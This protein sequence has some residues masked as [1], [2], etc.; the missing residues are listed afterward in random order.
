MARDFKYDYALEWVRGVISTTDIKELNQELTQIKYMGK[1][2]LI[3]ERLSQFFQDQLDKHV[4]LSPALGNPV[5][6][7]NNI[8]KIIEKEVL[9]AEEPTI[10]LFKEKQPAHWDV[11][12]KRVTIREPKIADFSPIVGILKQERGDYQG[13]G[14]QKRVDVALGRI[15]KFLGEPPEG[16]ENIREYKTA[17]RSIDR[18]LAN[19]DR[20]GNIKE[21][22]AIYNKMQE[23][24]AV[25]LDKKIPLKAQRD[26][27]EYLR[28]TNE[29]FMKARNS[30]L[31]YYDSEKGFRS[32]EELKNALL[33]RG[34]NITPLKTSTDF[35]IAA[36]NAGIGLRKYQRSREDKIDSILAVAPRFGKADLMKFDEGEINRIWNAEKRTIKQ[37][38]RFNLYV[39][40][41]LM[42]SNKDEVIEL[43]KE[44]KKRY[45]KASLEPIMG[46][47]LRKYPF[48]S[49]DQLVKAAYQRLATKATPYKILDTEIE[50]R[51]AKWKY[52]DEKKKLAPIDFAE[53]S[54][55]GER[56]FKRHLE[57]KKER[58]I[59]PLTGKPKIITDEINP[60]LFKSYQSNLKE[61]MAKFG[62]YNKLAEEFQSTKFELDATEKAIEKEINSVLRSRRKFR[63]WIAP[64]ISKRKL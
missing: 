38:P 25:S 28:Q 52:D 5:T 8:K 12:T 59:N 30:L 49:D 1:P 15:D 26:I 32:D 14:I 46:E 44:Q 18:Q 41:A 37:K 7:R 4:S 57:R 64:K 48:A 51:F 11:R 34:V 6:Q 56:E 2:G 10:V 33:R 58:T 36:L 53:L 63:K 19:A 22:E 55:L 20:V 43:F 21:I 54:M 35:R 27:K 60:N 39:P 61:S 40:V 9:P 31:K 13:K 17:Y 50:K 16:A 42:P 47:L 62:E 45:N 23:A 3:Q 24:A 29:L